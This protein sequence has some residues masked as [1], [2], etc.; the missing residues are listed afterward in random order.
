MSREERNKENIIIR[1]V[2]KEEETNKEVINKEV[3]NQEVIIQE[4]IVHEGKKQNMMVK[5]GD[6]EE[7]KDN[8]NP[9]ERMY[10]KIPISLKALDIIIVVLITVFVI[11]MLYFIIRR[12]S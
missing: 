1:D 9:K 10:D 7:R 8:R 3:I 12:F 11:L 2:M 6:K 4:A 5:D